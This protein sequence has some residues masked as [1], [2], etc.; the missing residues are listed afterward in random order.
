MK[1]YPNPSNLPE[2][3]ALSRIAAVDINATV[4]LSR[5]ASHPDMSYLGIG[6]TLTDEAITAL[7]APPI[8][9][10]EDIPEFYIDPVTRA[11]VAGGGNVVLDITGIKLL[12]YASASVASAKLH[13]KISNAGIEYHAGYVCSDWNGGITNCNTWVTSY[14]MTGDPW[15]NSQ[16]ILAAIDTELGY[17]T[18]I[19]INAQ[20]KVITLG[21]IGT[22]I[23]LAGKLISYGANDSAGAGYRLVR[24]PN[25]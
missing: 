14:R 19:T 8:T 12:D 24:V 17:D 7:L 13:M 10:T 23:E 2:I 21:T 16:L 1:M 11:L 5:V 20:N 18:R 25:A 4:I 15:S 22:G 3:V 6:S 9:E